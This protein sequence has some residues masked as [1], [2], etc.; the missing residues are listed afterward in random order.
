MVPYMFKKSDPVSYLVPWYTIEARLIYHGTKN[1]AL[2]YLLNNI[3][4]ERFL[5]ENNSSFIN[6]L[7]YNLNQCKTI[8]SKAKLVDIYYLFGIKMHNIRN[9][10]VDSFSLTDLFC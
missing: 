7:K 8:S 1:E 3:Y 6:A 2:R 10:C 5:N 9:Y 4:F